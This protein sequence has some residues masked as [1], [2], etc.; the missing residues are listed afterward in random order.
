MNPDCDK[1]DNHIRY[2]NVLYSDGH[3]EGFKDG[4]WMKKAGLEQSLKH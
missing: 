2:G 3:V 1:P 4:D